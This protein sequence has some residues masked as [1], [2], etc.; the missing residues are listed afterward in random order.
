[1]NFPSSFSNSVR[2]LAV[3]QVVDLLLIHRPFGHWLVHDRLDFLG[4][5]IEDRLAVR[6]RTGFSSASNLRA[7]YLNCLL[8]PLRQPPAIYSPVP[9]GVAKGTSC[10]AL[11]ERRGAQAE[12]ILSAESGRIVIV[13]TRAAAFPEPE[14]VARHIGDVR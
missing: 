5:F 13:A 9:C 14:R 12:I 1:L 4:E 8:L 10:A 3:G 7:M 11:E 2:D 6:S